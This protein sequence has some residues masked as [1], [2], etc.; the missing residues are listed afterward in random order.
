MYLSYMRCGLNWINLT[1]VRDQWRFA[2]NIVMKLVTDLLNVL[3]TVR[4]S[5]RNMFFLVCLMRKYN[6]SYTC[7]FSYF[8][9]MNSEI[10]SDGHNETL[11][12]RTHLTGIL[13]ASSP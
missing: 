6:N 12:S 7:A 13:S 2:V 5:I 11:F 8:R 4:L 10:I 9:P 1:Q 3:A